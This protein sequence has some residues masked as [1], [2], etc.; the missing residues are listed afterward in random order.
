M[1]RITLSLLVF[2]FLALTCCMLPGTVTVNFINH[3]SYSLNFKLDDAYFPGG[4]FP[5]TTSLLGKEWAGISPGTHTLTAA[6]NPPVS[7]QNPVS[8]TVDLAA[9]HMF[10]WTI[11]DGLS[12]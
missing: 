1:K 5:P 4:P 6:T 7:G 9:N 11:T 2:V 3:S 12:D 10:T 8:K